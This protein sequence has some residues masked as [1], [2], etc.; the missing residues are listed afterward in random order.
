VTPPSVTPP[1]PPVPPPVIPKPRRHRRVRLQIPHL[2]VGQT[3]NLQ[4][5]LFTVLQEQDATA[6]LSITIDAV[7]DAGIDAD[8]LDRRIVEGLEQLHIDVTWQ[9][10]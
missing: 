10:E 3:M 7:S 9:A 8:V 1:T 2:S 5:Y 4:A 6:T